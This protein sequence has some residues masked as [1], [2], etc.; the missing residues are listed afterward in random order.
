[1]KFFPVGIVYLLSTVL[2]AVLTNADNHVNWYDEIII[3][4]MRTVT[5]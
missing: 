5:S 3:C 2:E 4:G 1:M